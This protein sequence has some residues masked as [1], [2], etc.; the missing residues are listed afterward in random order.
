MDIWKQIN[1]LSRGQII[2]LLEGIRI[3]CFDDEPTQVLREALFESIESG[4]IQ[5]CQLEA[6]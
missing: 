2:E 4:D 3:A 5:L 1:Q 6:Y